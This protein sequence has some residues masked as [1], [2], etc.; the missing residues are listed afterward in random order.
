MNQRA[1]SWKENF[2]PIVAKPLIRLWGWLLSH[3]MRCTRAGNRI[4]KA[5]RDANETSPRD[6]FA[7]KSGKMSGQA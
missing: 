3:T 5:L 4:E 7:F 6:V 1:D 2:Q